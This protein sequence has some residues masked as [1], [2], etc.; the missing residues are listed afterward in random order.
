MRVLA[1]AAALV[2]SFALAGCSG[3]TDSAST[4]SSTTTSGNTTTLPPNLPPVVVVKTLVAGAEGNVSLVG[5]NVTVD[6]TGTTDDGKLAVIAVAAEDANRTYAP[7][8]LYVN[9]AFQTATFAFDL[10]G[11]VNITVAAVDDRNADT[12]VAVPLFVNEATTGANLVAMRL[13]VPT[14]AGEPTACDGPTGQPAVDEG[15]SFV[16]TFRV[17]PGAT[18]VTAAVATGEATIALCDPTGAPISA[19]GTS[20]TSTPG[21]VFAPPAG[22]DGYFVQVYSAAPNQDPGAVSVAIVVHYEPAPPASPAP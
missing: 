13:L 8:L 22:T 4:T 1:L 12:T 21:T 20:V 2:V 6:A 5:Q 18:F 11:R 14:Q 17:A 16:T 15:M 10:P 3:D 7:Q 19:A 9:D